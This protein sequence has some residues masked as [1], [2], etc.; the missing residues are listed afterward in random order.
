MSSMMD[1]LVRVETF[2]G[3]LWLVNVKEPMVTS[4]VEEVKRY[5]LRIN[6]GNTFIQYP[7]HRISK[8]AYT[9][10]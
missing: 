8:I 1:Y 7:P 6:D 3:G 9:L 10:Y 2:D 4:Y 5:G